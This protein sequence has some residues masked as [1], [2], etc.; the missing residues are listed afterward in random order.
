MPNNNHCKGSFSNR[1]IDLT[2]QVVGRQ[3]LINLLP[4]RSVLIPRRLGKAMICIL[5]MP[6]PDGY[7]RGGLR[8]FRVQTF[9]KA[10]LVCTKPLFAGRPVFYASCFSSL[11]KADGLDDRDLAS[12]R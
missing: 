3:T 6:F 9:S 1:L 5:A 11:R 7:H 2:G 10:S 4:L 12:I 8:A